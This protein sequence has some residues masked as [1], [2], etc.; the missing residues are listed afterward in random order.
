[1]CLWFV[2]DLSLVYLQVMTILVSCFFKTK[3]VVN[4]MVEEIVLGNWGLKHLASPNWISKERMLCKF[5]CHNPSL[6][7]AR[8]QAKREA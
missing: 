6:G 7:L 4:V 1:M 5:Y 3:D 8:L 2:K